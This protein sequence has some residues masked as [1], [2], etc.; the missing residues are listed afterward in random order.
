MP[1]YRLDIEY[2]GTDWHGWQ[3]QPD[4]KT[5][6][7]AIESALNVA[8][9]TPVSIVGSGRTDA[10]VHALGQVA[11]FQ[12]DAPFDSERLFGSLNG[13]LPD[14]I[15]IRKLAQTHS[16]FHAR[17]DATSRQYRYQI[18]TLPSVLD[19]RTRWFLRPVPNVEKMNE[20]A[21]HLLGS[22]DFTSFC[23]VI[24]DTENKRCVIDS[25]SWHAVK[26]Q[27]GAY[28]FVIKADRFLHGM[29][30]AIVGTLIGVG[31]DKRTIESIPNLIAAGDRTLAGFAVPSKGLI[32]ERVEY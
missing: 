20:A 7:G 25:A 21:L 11:H 13:I 1:T 8:L 16:E 23:K 17:F 19:R 9:R 14:S 3:I 22:H 18:T 6:Q 30:R 15:A 26:G 28:D 5:I 32:L 24:S 29:V 12:H 31:H 27:I 10:G 2:D 4:A